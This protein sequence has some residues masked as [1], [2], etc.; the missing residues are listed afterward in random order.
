MKKCYSK[1][2]LLTILVL[3]SCEG[4]FVADDLAIFLN[5]PADNTACLE[6]TREG[7][8][9]SIPFEWEIDG[10]LNGLQIEIQELDGAKSPND[11]EPI[12]ENITS[13]ETEISVSLDYGKWYQWKVI[14]SA[15]QIE[16]DIYTFFS[17]GEPQINRA[18]FPAEINIIKSDEGVLRFT[19]TEPTDPEN[20]PLKY[21]AYFGQT[22]DA[23]TEIKK[24]MIVP[25]TLEIPNPAIGTEYYLRIVS[26]EVFEDNT[27]GNS[28]TAIVKVTADN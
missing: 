26:K 12:V 11:T 13:S 18:P 23:P 1:L 17:E 14:S 19:W 4:E 25:E 24:D 20:N 27:I 22:I 5:F 7:G 6:G 9:V 2:L 10:S 21:D 3:M 15:P 28:S 16:S 8:K